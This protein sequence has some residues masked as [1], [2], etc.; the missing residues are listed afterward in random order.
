MNL[1][2][3]EFIRADGFSVHV[4]SVAQGAANRLLRRVPKKRIR[5]KNSVGASVSIPTD[6]VLRILVNGEERWCNPAASNA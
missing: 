6:Q 1:V 4:P 2:V 5:I 3:L